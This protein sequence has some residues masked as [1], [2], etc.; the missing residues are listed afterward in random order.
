[1][2]TSAAQADAFY[3]EAVEHEVVWGIK[4]DNG[5]PAPETPEGR[6]MPFWSLKSRAERIVSVVPAYSGFA[7]VPI[8]FD[9]WRTRWLPALDRDGLRVGL[10]W[11]GAKATGYDV[12]PNEI[13]Q[14]LEA[15]QVG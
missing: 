1:M 9:E 11:A 13:E 12:A 14:S 2:S 8:P 5:F 4:D 3:K 15:R 7:V 10:N 6:A